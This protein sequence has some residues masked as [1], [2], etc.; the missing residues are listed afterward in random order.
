MADDEGYYL[1]AKAVYTDAY[2]SG[3][4]AMATT[5]NSVTTNSPPMFADET[6]TRSVA[7]N[8]A[9]G[10]NVGAPVMATDDDNDTLSYMLSG[11]DAMYFT[12]DRMGQIM[13]GADAMLD[14]ETK[15]SYMVT[16]TANTATDPDGASDSIMVTITT[17]TA[18]PPASW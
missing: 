7:E 11:D 4:Y 3:K 1:M 8:T 17:R 6:A 5:E 14:Y 15:M 18:P 10:M 2:G 9:A 12:I 13:V 16:V